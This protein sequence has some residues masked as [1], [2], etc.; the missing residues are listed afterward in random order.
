[1]ESK[2]LKPCKLMHW[3]V[4]TKCYAKTIYSFDIYGIDEIDM[5]TNFVLFFLC[6]LLFEKIANSEAQ[7]NLEA[8][9]G[10]GDLKYCYW[11][12][13]KYKL[14]RSKG[15]SRTHLI[16]PTWRKWLQYLILLP[17][18]FLAVSSDL[19]DSTQE[20]HIGP[21][22]FIHDGKHPTG[23]IM[24]SRNTQVS[25][26]EKR[27]NKENYTLSSRNVVTQNRD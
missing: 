5:N 10:L 11:M 18:T 21:T 22:L 25:H 27:N 23:K 2:K 16:A 1:M 19:L 3:S 7:D 9:T 26:K 17:T 8:N 14:E 12:I 13:R 15:R 6:I 20:Q 24:I 4:K